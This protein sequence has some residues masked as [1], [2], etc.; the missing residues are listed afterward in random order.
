MTEDRRK[1]ERRIAVSHTAADLAASPMRRQGDRRV[2]EA[3]D[4]PALGL[5]AM[6]ECERLRAQLVEAQNIAINKDTDLDQLREAIIELRDN[7][8]D[9][10]RDVLLS[11]ISPSGEAARTFSIVADMIDKLL[12]NCQPL[13]R[14]ESANG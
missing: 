14:V 5:H 9:S 3:A 2:T 8:R 10:A 1:G 13:D 6:R 4:F 12:T 7:L 11:R